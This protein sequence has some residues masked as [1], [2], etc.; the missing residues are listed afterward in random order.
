VNELSTV[1]QTDKGIR[2]GEVMPLLAL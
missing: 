1:V 2:S